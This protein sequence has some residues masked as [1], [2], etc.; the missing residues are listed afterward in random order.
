MEQ[1]Y[2]LGIKA[3]I[4][5][6]EGKFLVLKVNPEKLRDTDEVYWDIPGGRVQVGSTAND[7]LVREVLEETGL[8]VSSI[9]K[10]LGTYLSNIMIPTDQGAVGLLLS[11]YQVHVKEGNIQLSD[12]HTNADWVSQSELGER[13]RHKYP[14]EFLQMLVK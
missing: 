14:D 9:G 13:L 5:N 3:L 1:L 2:H 7:T 6:G 11:V 4:S 12:E 10:S 8:M